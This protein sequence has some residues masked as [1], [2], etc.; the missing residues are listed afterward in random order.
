MLEQSRRN[1][2]DIYLGFIYVGAGDGRKR[3]QRESVV[4]LSEWS[5]VVMWQIEIEMQA[6]KK[7]DDFIWDVIKN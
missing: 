1:E 7:E 5:L 3:V 2:C 6:W 4:Y